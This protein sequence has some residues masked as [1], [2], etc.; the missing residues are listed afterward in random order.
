MALLV[1][2]EPNASSQPRCAYTPA[3]C[4]NSAVTSVS[5]SFQRLLRQLA[6]REE[7]ARAGDAAGLQAFALQRIEAACR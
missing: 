3:N 1:P 7:A 4:W 2:E 5:A 6:V